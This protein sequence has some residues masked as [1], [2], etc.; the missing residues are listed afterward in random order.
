MLQ[1]LPI[2]LLYPTVIYSCLPNGHRSALLYCAT[3]GIGLV[4]A[5]FI[6]L[7]YGHAQHVVV[8]I[9]ADYGKVGIG[10]EIIVSCIILYLSVGEGLRSH[11]SMCGSEKM[12]SSP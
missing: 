8:D 4:A 6:L 11:V 5:G 7:Y 9:S 10:W 1:L 12:Q 2:Y 3:T